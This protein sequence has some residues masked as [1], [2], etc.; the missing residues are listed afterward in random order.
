MRLT[1]LPR[2]VIVDGR[3][4]RP[5]RRQQVVPRAPVE[6]LQAERDA[7]AMLLESAQEVY[8]E[9]LGVIVLMS[10]V[11]GD[12]ARQVVER[13]REIGREF[14]RAA[15]AGRWERPHWYRHKP[16]PQRRKKEWS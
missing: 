4:P 15:G 16:L 2:T 7:Y 14:L 12:N 13:A 6:I 3:R 11:K 5:R 1:D 8:R 9:A 10:N